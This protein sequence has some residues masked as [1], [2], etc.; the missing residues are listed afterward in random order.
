MLL[1]KQV[2]GLFFFF[3]LLLDGFVFFFLA[4]EGEFEGFGFAFEVLDR[5]H[6]GFYLFPEGLVCGWFGWFRSF[7]GGGGRGSFA[8]ESL[9]RFCGV[10]SFRVWGYNRLRDFERL[11]GL[12][13][14]GNGKSLVAM[15]KPRVY[16][17]RSDSRCQGRK[18]TSGLGSPTSGFYTRRRHGCA[19]SLAAKY[20]ATEAKF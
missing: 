16:R 2:D 1:G 15:S 3:E 12:G 5:V 17:G 7:E 20:N 4:V 19:T 14:G 18:K 10:E 8:F 9:K 11:G 6:D 13:F